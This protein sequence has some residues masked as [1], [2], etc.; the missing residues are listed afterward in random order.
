MPKATLRDVA[1]RS[2]F[3]ITTVSHVLNDVPGK[4][5]PEA[6]RERVRA[7]AAELAY[8][9]N[10]LAQGLRLRRTNT[11]GFIS[12]HIAT[13]PHAGQTILGAQ[14]AAAD[15]DCLLLLMNSGSD[16]EL[17]NREIQALRDRQ[18]DGI[19]YAAEYHRVL[20]P[21]AAL[22]GVP[23]VLLDARPADAGFSSIVPDEVGGAATAVKE[24]IDHGHRRIGFVTNITDIP[25]TALRLAGFKK[26]LKTAH[27]HFSRALVV[28][29]ISE[30]HGGFRAARVLLD[31]QPADRP[32]AL[33][34]FNDRMAMG[35]YQAA[36]ECGLRIPEDVSIVGFDNQELIAASLR[37]GLTTVALPHYQMGQWAVHALMRTVEGSA[38]GSLRS[39]VMPCPIVRR[40][41]VG[42]PPRS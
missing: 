7:A 2:G 33:F 19:I 5:I 14:D 1:E 37:P 35:A 31:R 8:T 20:T 27:R 26:A 22:A 16:A 38:N 9:P 11:L 3:S 36:A 40:G 30:A 6:T 42:P 13:S 41:S 23:A 12:D 4:R 34:C 10:R 39:E 32:T 28:E 29:D 18:V 25:A 17:E 24:L 21:P 15:Y